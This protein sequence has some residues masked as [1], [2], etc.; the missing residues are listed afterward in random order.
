[1]FKYVNIE[2]LKN[3]I[4]LNKSKVQLVDVDLNKTLT[5]M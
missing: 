1:M 3:K 5:V 2:L 4:L